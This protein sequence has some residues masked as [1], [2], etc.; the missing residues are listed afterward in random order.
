MLDLAE[1]FP[2]AC[3]FVSNHVGPYRTNA[4]SFNE[5]QSEEQYLCTLATYYI[6]LFA[7]LTNLT[8]T[9]RPLSLSPNREK[10]ISDLRYLAIHDAPVFSTV[11]LRDISR[12]IIVQLTADSEFR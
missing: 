11:M 1:A 4:I 10:L 2:F 8:R 9:Q 5:S 3:G 7:R 12:L 6:G